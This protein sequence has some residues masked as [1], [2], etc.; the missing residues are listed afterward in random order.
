MRRVR[1][2]SIVPIVFCLLAVAALADSKQK[3]EIT[4]SKTV[5][6]SSAQLEPGQYIVRWEGTGANVQV[7][8]MHEGEEVA[9]VKGRVIQERNR[10]SS[11]TTNEGENGSRILTKIT[12]PEVTLDLASGEASIAQ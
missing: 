1:F 5:T 12:F 7:K 11:F 8:F 10:H 4:F 2:I 6:I 3:G 9:S